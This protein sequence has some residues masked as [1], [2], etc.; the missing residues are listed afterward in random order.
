MNKKAYIKP[1]TEVLVMETLQ[2]MAASGEP[3]IAT[4]NATGD[5]A[6]SNGR[7]GTWGDLWGGEE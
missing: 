5:D 4:G 2:V 1:S 3:R 7:R 6:L